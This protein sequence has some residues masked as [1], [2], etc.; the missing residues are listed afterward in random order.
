MKFQCDQCKSVLNSAAVTAGMSVTCPVCGAETECRPLGA[1]AT[2]RAVAD[3]GKQI[4]DG[5]GLAQNVGEKMSSIIGIEKLK[6]FSLS[7]LFSD[8]FSHHTREEVENYFTVGTEKSTP[9]ILDV[10]TSWPKPWIFTRMVIASLVLY[11]LLLLGWKMWEN[12]KL[13]PGL[14]F[15][16]SFAIPISTLVLFIELNVR[17]NVSFYM[18]AR[19]A[20]LGGI[21]SL[22]VTHLL[23]DIK[24]V[25]SILPF[26][27]V[28]SEDIIGASIAGPVEETA[29]VLAMVAV[30]SAAKYRYRLNGLLVG[31]SVGTGF[32]A[33][34]T[35]GYALE[36]LF[37]GG[38]DMM[39]NVISTRGLL[40]PFMH[41]VWSAIAG[42]ALWRVINGQKFRWS[43][44]CDEKFIRLFIVPVVLHMIWNSGLDL[45]YHAEWIAAGFVGWFVCF[46]LVGDGLREIAAE[47]KEAQK[48]PDKIVVI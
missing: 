10:D 1:P 47:Q 40:S 26:A 15:V 3:G 39:S 46:S 33:F 31:A 45:P 6:G 44:L 48:V 32:A 2:L 27:G 35:M 9:D 16:G 7:D 14:I 13:L 12:P 42:C 34:E 23:L 38:I 41:I 18:V 30:A 36:C 29:K 37:A 22:I 4:D 11:F 8:V 21:I 28:L 5:G 25:T 43:M 20:L 24:G 17:R 19:L